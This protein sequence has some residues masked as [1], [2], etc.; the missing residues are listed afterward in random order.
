MTADASVPPTSTSAE[1]SV[2]RAPHG[3]TR[4]VAA[5]VRI[6][7]LVR[8]H[9]IRALRIGFVALGV[10]LVLGQVPLPLGGAFGYRSCARNL[11]ILFLAGVLLGG[12]RR[13]PRSQVGP[14]LL[15]FLLVA[16]GSLLGSEAG[17]GNLRVLASG[18]GVFY[19]ARRLSDA[20]GERR[21]LVHWLGLIVLGVLVRE[22]WHEPSLLA[23]RAS[24]RLAVVTENP[25]TLG[26]LGALLT[27]LFLA[28][29]GGARDGLL[30]WAYA[31][32]GSTIVLIS[33][34]RAA[35]IGL[36]LGS[37]L[38]ALDAGVRTERAGT[39]RTLV[40]VALGVLAVAI[41]TVS[42]ERSFA[43]AQRLRIAATSLSLFADHWLTGIG[44][45]GQSLARLFPQRHLE[46]HGESLFLFHSHD[47]YLDV[48]VGTGVI[49][50]AA[51]AGLLL[52]LARGALRGVRGARTPQE[53]TEAVASGVTIGIFVLLS[54]SD[55]P[56]YHGRIV[57]LVAVSWAV[58]ESAWLRTSAS[59]AHKSGSSG[60][61]TP[62]D[63]EHSR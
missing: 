37:L 58:T 46:L 49:G 3:W 63:C 12:S 61:A 15:A 36:A 34:S 39:V 31:V 28:R 13:V 11:A 38:L 9:E 5:R 33:Y 53:R 26:F 6:A 7:E 17:A 18:L 30:A 22:L 57:V 35:W 56:L 19:A 32:C 55:T 44:F 1:I 40:V 27:P 60:G 21:W 50:A 29:L 48:L 14:A 8:R 23:L 43:D 41:A 45:G 25:N 2:Q 24:Q 4:T 10:A 16:A 47:L 42:G 62:P 52:V 54:L 51:L 20:D 59:G